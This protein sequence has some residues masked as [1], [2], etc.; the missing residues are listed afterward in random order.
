M[1]SPMRSTF[2]AVRAV[3]VEPRRRSPASAPGGSRTSNLL[4]CARQGDRHGYAER[5]GGTFP[6]S[7]TGTPQITFDLAAASW[8]AE[9][10]RFDELA[11]GHWAIGIDG[12]RSGS[13]VT[14]DKG[15]V[16]MREGPSNSESQ[17]QARGLG[18]GAIA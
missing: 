9:P 1:R 6:L 3:Y 15:G 5:N 4:R 2:Q 17:A 10:V 11:T 18:A 16:V 7:A 14:H 12:V 13:A 8:R